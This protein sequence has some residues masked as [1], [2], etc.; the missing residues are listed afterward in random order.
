MYKYWLI[1]GHDFFV[2][3]RQQNGVHGEAIVQNALKA[4]REITC[5]LQKSDGLVHCSA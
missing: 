5:K 1:A 3:M 2:R 4:L